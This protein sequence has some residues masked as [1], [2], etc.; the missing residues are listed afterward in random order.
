MKHFHK[1]Y[2][3]GLCPET[4]PSAI[5]L[6]N[7]IKLI[8][9]LFNHT[10]QSNYKC[11]FCEKIFSLDV[12]LQTHTSTEHS[13]KI[14]SEFK[15]VKKE[16]K[17]EFC[18]QLFKQKKKFKN[19]V[20]STHRE[21]TKFKCESC[22][23]KTFWSKILLKKHT[24]KVHRGHKKNK[25]KLCPELFS[26]SDLLKNHM[27][28]VHEKENCDICDKFYNIYQIKKHIKIV[29]E[30]KNADNEEFR[31]NCDSCD[32]SFA[33]V[34]RL[35]GHNQSVH[36]GKTYKCVFC[37]KNLGEPYTLKQHIRFVHKDKQIKC[38]FC[39]NETT[40]PTARILRK[41]VYSVH[42]GYKKHP[43]IK[44]GKCFI[45]LE[46]VQEHIQSGHNELKCGKKC[47]FVTRTLHCL[48]QRLKL[49]FVKF[50]QVEGNR[51]EEIF[52]KNIDF[53]V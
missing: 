1:L 39:E 53:S 50:F 44:C 9:N 12:D 46:K 13:T 24:R 20:K 49:T 22:E 38:E 31:F 16:Y 23:N 29:H 25:C 45:N 3:C 6:T 36:E 30:G 34:Q 14:K 7:H 32:K 2:K 4:L 42:K 10:E 28:S 21:G 51:S 27:K 48:P 15:K 37:D 19:H 11:D 40:F 26:R 17:C 43:C 47:K 41:H 33:S 35:K 5:E 18:A 52:S 8:H